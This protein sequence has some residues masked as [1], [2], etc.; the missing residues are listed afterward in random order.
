MDEDGLNHGNFLEAV[1]LLAQFDP[2][3]AAHVESLQKNQTSY[4]SKRIQNEL[5]A[6]MARMV[7]EAII[8][9]IKK[10]GPFGIMFDTT[11]DMSRREQMSEIVRYVLI[12]FE[13]M[14]YE[15]KESFLDFI[16]IKGPRKDAETL[17]SAILHKLRGDG[18]TLDKCVAQVRILYSYLIYLT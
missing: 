8:K 18:L 5:I 6:L 1:R 12:D 4:L 15:V 10:S 11:P 14:S 2:F 7:R 16:E 3:L 13:E 17:S 9:D